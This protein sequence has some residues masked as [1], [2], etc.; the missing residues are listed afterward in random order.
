MNKRPGANS[1]GP[2]HLTAK[3]WS[4]CHTQPQPPLFSRLCNFIPPGGVHHASLRRNRTRSLHPAPVHV[5]AQPKPPLRLLRHAQ[6]VLLLQ[7]PHGP[8]AHHRRLRRIRPRPPSRPP[9][10][11]RRPGGDRSPPSRQNHRRPPRRTHPLLPPN[12]SLQPGR[13][14]TYSQSRKDAHRSR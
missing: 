12:R 1:V 14:G 3:V 13:P 5:L 7:A 2:S 8:V 11:P 10:H 4:I 6:R 9:V